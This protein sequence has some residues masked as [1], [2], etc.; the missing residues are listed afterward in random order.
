MNDNLS[1]STSKR[2]K[3]L[4]IKHGYTMETLAEKLGVTKSTIAKWE[5]GYVKNMRNDM[6][7]A[8]SKIF[9]VSPLYIAGYDTEEKSNE[10]QFIELYRNLNQEQKK[11]I[12]DMITALSSN[13]E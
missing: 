1:D 9:D 13:K 11:L 3:E 6:V 8:L 10:E 7:M 4:R 2:I 12:D 5:N